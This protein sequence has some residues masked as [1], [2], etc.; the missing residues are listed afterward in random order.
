MLLAYRCYSIGSSNTYNITTE[1]VEDLKKNAKDVV[2]ICTTRGRSDIAIGT[3]W[4]N[5]ADNQIEQCS[6]TGQDGAVD[7]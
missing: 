5:A 6:T 2:N 4:L 3:D 1:Q 7:Q